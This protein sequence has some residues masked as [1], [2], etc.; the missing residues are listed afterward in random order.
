VSDSR[1]FDAAYR[2]WKLVFNEYGFNQRSA[3]LPAT[4]R[5]HTNENIE[6]GYRDNPNDG[7]G[8]S[9]KALSLRRN[10]GC[11]YGGRHHLYQWRERKFV[12]RLDA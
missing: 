7:Y 6:R 10:A 2:R 1:S 4:C 11:Q 12:S 9:Q 8:V 3:G 5:I